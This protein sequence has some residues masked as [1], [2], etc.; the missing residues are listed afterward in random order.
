MTIDISKVSM[1][2]LQVLWHLSRQDAHGYALIQDLSKHRSSPLT[3]GTLYPLLRRFSQHGLIAIS[4]TGDR[5]KKT[6]TLTSDGK[7][8][9]D[10]LAGEFVETFDGIYT[11]Y[12]CTACTHFLHDKESI[13]SIRPSS[14]GS[15]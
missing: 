8:V 15:I 9:L 3:P 13:P 6:Y 4:Q 12:H 7:R 10:K 1:L 2:E 11:H 14:K 5:E